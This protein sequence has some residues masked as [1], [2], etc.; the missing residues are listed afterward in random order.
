MGPASLSGVVWTGGRGAA[1][2]TGAAGDAS[3]GL[4][5]FAV[6]GLGAAT[7]GF[8]GGGAAAG[9]E[10]P[11][12]ALCLAGAG[13]VAVAAV[14]GFA[15]VVAAGFV[16]LPVAGFAVAGLVVAGFVGAGLVAAGL[17]VAGLL[18]AGLVDVPADAG[19]LAVAAPVDVVWAV[20]GTTSDTPSSARA[21]DHREALVRAISLPPARKA[22]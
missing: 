22:G 16:A 2:V 7:V 18:L 15:A 8:G 5:D 6:G 11:D 9:L 14:L 12:G 4:S 13:L 19:G 3:A 1:G 17:G 20:A 21:N 10:P